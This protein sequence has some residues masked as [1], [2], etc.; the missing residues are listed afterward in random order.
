MR[1][2]LT[3]GGTG[4]HIFPALALWRY[5]HQHHPDAEVLYVGGEQGLERDIVP[6]EGLPFVTVPAAPLRRQMS[7]SVLRTVAVT[8]RGYREARRLLQ[9][10]H[11]DVVLG[12][13]GYVTLPVVWAAQR[14]GIPTVIWEGNAAPGLSNRLCARRADAVAL[15]FPGAEAAFRGAGRVIVTGNPRASEVMAASPERLAQAR[16]MYRIDPD[17]RLVVCYTGSRGSETVN[18]VIAQVVPRFAEVPRWQLLFVTGEAH[19][20]RVMERLGAVPDNVTVV[21][22]IHDMPAVLPQASAVVTRAGSST[23]AEICALGVPSVLIPSPYVTANHQEHNARRL[24]E[25]GAAWMIREAE[26][27]P[28]ALWQALATVLHPERAARMREAARRLGTPDAVARLY[29]VVLSVARR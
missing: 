8:Y 14:L 7:P 6:R 9:S 29:E 15:A 13:G 19:F 28:S 11:P 16:A 12:T 3:G 1:L 17:K 2:V 21:P 27:T 18:G 23:L 25:Q 10:F 4:G 22:F 5:L 24:A 20:A 26:L